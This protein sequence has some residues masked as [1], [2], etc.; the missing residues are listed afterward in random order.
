MIPMETIH[1]FKPAQCTAI[2]ASNLI[3]ATQDMMKLSQIWSRLFSPSP[4]VQ[5]LISMNPLLILSDDE[6][7]KLCRLMEHGLHCWAYWSLL[8]EL[9]VNEGVSVDDAWLSA[10][11]A[12]L[13]DL[14]RLDTEDISQHLVRFGS[15]NI[16]APHLQ[17]VMGKTKCLDVGMSIRRR[18]TR[19][20]PST[21][22]NDEVFELDAVETEAKSAVPTAVVSV[23][24]SPDTESEPLT[25]TVEDSQRQLT[26]VRTAKEEDLVFE[27]ES[28]IADRGSSLEAPVP[29][30]PGILEELNAALDGALDERVDVFY[31]PVEDEPPSQVLPLTTKTNQS[32][33]TKRNGTWPRQSQHRKCQAQHEPASSRSTR[34]NGWISADILA[35]SSPGDFDL[36]ALLPKEEIRGP[37]HLS[38]SARGKLPMARSL[39]TRVF[40][41]RIVA[42]PCCGSAASPTLPRYDTRQTSS[43]GTGSTS[44]G[45]SS[46][47]DTP[48]SCADA[49][50]PSSWIAWADCCSTTVCRCYDEIVEHCSE[51]EAKTKDFA[52]AAALFHDVCRQQPEVSDSDSE[53]I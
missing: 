2:M 15:D 19:G 6:A 29:S 3:M 46:T 21:S 45:R 38:E 49:R 47:T 20:V 4:P 23:A 25:P 35:S 33:Q 40:P 9:S 39:S 22:H 37:P 50:R 17:S 10:L 13:D 31:E 8:T 43:E 44:Q 18:S 24:S 12:E 5:C 42:L 48:A 26:A 30:S 41:D 52:D 36:E 11:G 32:A 1:R 53:Q 27:D 16:N 7:E 28:A 34:E 14:G 51:N